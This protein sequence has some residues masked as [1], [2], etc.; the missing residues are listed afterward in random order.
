MVVIK[1][2]SELQP[3]GSMGF[4]VAARNGFML[5]LVFAIIQKG[6]VELPSLTQKGKKGQ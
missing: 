1:R 3:L 2:R 5:I 6:R 4:L